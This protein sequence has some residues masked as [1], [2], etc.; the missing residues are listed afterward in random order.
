MQAKTRRHVG[1]YRRKRSEEDY[2]KISID[3]IIRKVAL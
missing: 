3:R 1:S 2:T